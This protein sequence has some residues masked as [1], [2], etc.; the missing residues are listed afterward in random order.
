MPALD[1]GSK[2]IVESVDVA[3]YLNDTYPDPPLYPAEPQACQE[4]KEL[5]DK[6][7]PL[8]GVFYNIVLK[9]QDKTPEEWLKM[10]YPHL[11]LFEEELKKRGTTFFFG[12]KP[13]M[14]NKIIKDKVPSI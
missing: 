1:I 3:N 12:D 9:L 4:D 13:G 8:T 14:V 2:V 10:L 11:E 7:G 6:I 5:I